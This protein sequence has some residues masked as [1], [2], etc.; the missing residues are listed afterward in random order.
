EELVVTAG[1]A[2]GLNDGGAALV[3]T[4]LEFA[5]AHGLPV[6]ARIT[7]YASGGTEP[8]DLFFA[9]VVAVRKLMERTG[10]SMD[11]YDLVEVNE[12]FAVQAIADMREL[13]MDPER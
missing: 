10:A 8:Q 1:N 13:G 12:A 7:G 2:P 9:P 5:R 4:S 6:R 11:S 3:V